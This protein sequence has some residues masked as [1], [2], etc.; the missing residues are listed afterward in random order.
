MMGANGMSGA[1]PQPTEHRGATPRATQR[2][3][4]WPVALVGTVLWLVVL[5]LAMVLIPHAPP[6]SRP[7]TVPVPVVPVGAFATRRYTDP[8]GESMTYY[9]Y[10]PASFAPRQS[11]PL[12]LVL[13]GSG[14]RGDPKHDPGQNRGA[15]IDQEYVQALVSPATQR[16]WPCFVVAPQLLGDQR[17]VNAPSTDSSYKL[18]PRPN[19]SLALAVEIVLSLRER[20]PQIDGSRIYVEGISIGAF[21]T[22]E[23]AERWPQLFAAAIPMAGAGDPSAAAALRQVPVWAFQGGSDGN[24]PA[25]A[26]RLMVQAVRE[27]GGTACYTEYPG[28]GHDIWNTERPLNDPKVLAW[29]FAQRKDLGSIARPTTCP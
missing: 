9:F 15:L 6:T 7:R 16:R 25:E 27:E 10:G 13:H 26:S 11:Y 20:Y 21:G 4:A 22:W 29:L 19:P 14:E 8:I 18:A 23:A 12:V 3:S 5:W 1:F 17:W 28:A 24:P 2:P